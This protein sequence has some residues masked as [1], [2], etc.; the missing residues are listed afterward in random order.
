MIRRSSLLGLLLFTAVTLLPAG[1]VVTE[2]N[3]IASTAIVKNGGKPPSSA[4][5]WFAYTA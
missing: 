2:W 5:I 3:T 1:N 4:A